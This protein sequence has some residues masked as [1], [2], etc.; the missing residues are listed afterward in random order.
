MGFVVSY[1]PFLALQVEDDGGTPITAFDFQPTPESKRRMQRNRILFRP[2]A[3]GVQLYYRTT[4]E[5]LPPLLGEI[6]ERVQY[7][8][9]LRLTE[10]DFFVRHFPDFNTGDGAALHFDN[11]DGAGAIQA[12]G[13]ISQGATVDDTDAVTIGTMPFPA[14]IDLTGGVPVDVEVR[15]PVSGGALVT[16][17]VTAP[18]GAAETTVLLDASGPGA[19]LYRAVASIPAAFDRRIYTDA[20]AEH[21]IRGALDLYWETAQDSV[22]SPH[23]VVYRV[24]F[25]RR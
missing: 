23:G 6:T 10:A 15:D 11:L 4:P 7:S 25:Q 18:A 3:D 16:V 19:G 21:A 14:R 20:I 17:P 24:V 5:S 13:V 2:R 22:P 12:T 8:F 1:H 9:H